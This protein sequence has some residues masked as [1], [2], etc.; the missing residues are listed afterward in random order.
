M[1]SRSGQKLFSFWISGSGSRSAVLN[2]SATLADTMY[3]SKGTFHIVPSCY[4]D[5]LG[6]GYGIE[7]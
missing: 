6:T 2:G 5:T 4:R 1:R 7:I 3:D